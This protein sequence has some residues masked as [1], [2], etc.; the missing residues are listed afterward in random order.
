[1]FYHTAKLDVA[2]LYSSIMLSYRIHSCKDVEG[3]LLRVLKWLTQK[4]L[5]YK[6]LAKEKNDRAAEW[7]QQSLK[8][9]MNSVYGFYGT[10]GYPFNEMG[11]AEVARLG[12]ELLALIIA[13]I[14]D[15]GVIVAEA[16]TD[17]VIFSH[18]QPKKVEEAVN[19]A[20]PAGFKVELEFTVML[21]RLLVTVRT[22]LCCSPIVN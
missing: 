5:E 15:L 8:V 13:T 7:M 22:T 19:A 2:S 3:W 20:L 14:K 9:L 6:R 12:R 16:N 21:Q 10:S 11:A 4:R 17:G 1:M 18:P